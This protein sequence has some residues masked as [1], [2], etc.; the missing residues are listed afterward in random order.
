MNYNL[1]AIDMEALDDA[2]ALLRKCWPEMVDGYL[3]D[4]HMYIEN[5]KR[6]F[7]NGDKKE[8]A[9]NAHPLKSSSNSLGII[10]IGEIAKNM[11]HDTKDAIESGG[12]I[13]HLQELIPL[14]EEALER[15]EPK[16]RAKL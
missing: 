10:S 11:E 16:L 12:E 2:H 6:S 3:E 14:L 7:A 13:G 8:L 15:A 4:A 1:D 5:I 9:S